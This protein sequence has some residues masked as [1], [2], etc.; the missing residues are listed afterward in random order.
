VS[1]GVGT[2]VAAA[3]ALLAAGYGVLALVHLN[4]GT[5][6][7]ARGV[8]PVLAVQSGVVAVL[9]LVVL[10]PPWLISGALVLLAARVGYEAAA[11]RRPG[12]AALLSGGLTALCAALP[13]AG[14]PAAPLALAAAAVW[15]ALLGVRITGHGGTAAEVALYPG[16]PMVAMAAGASL[17][18]GPVL[19]F[20]AYILI[21][22][23]D[24]YAYLAGKSFGRRKAFPRLSPGKTVEGLAGGAVML[25]ATAGLAALVLDGVALLPALGFAALTGVAAVA[26]DLAASRLKRRAGVKDFPTVLPHM[27]GLLDQFDS[28]IGVSALLAVALALGGG[29]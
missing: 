21:E 19:L 24:S 6:A 27:G 3:L 2:L 1:F 20:A 17:P 15:V 18:P 11:I 8:W 29:T 14:V 22:T 10:G 23:F 9:C 4:P 26:G 25:L 5:R 7:A 12:R 28:W 13:L 16:L